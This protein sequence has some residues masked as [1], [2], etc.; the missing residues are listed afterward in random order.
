VPLI[1]AK[2]Y[3]EDPT[4]TDEDT[5]F[6]FEARLLYFAGFR[7]SGGFASPLDGSIDITGLG[8]GGGGGAPLVSA[9]MV[10]YNDPTGEDP[11]LSF[12]NEEVIG[13]KLLYFGKL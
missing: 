2:D 13:S 12:A 4:A 11:N 3:I 10:N 5:E 1:Y 9:F 7:G 8:G 6:D